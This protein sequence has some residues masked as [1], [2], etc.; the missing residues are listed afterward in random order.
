MGRSRLKSEGV[1]PNKHACQI[2][3]QSM[4]C[5][6]SL[7]SKRCWQTAEA[8]AVHCNSNCNGKD[9]DDDDDDNDKNVT[10][11]I[12]IIKQIVLLKVTI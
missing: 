1:V 4:L 2:S 6:I 7:A 9:D 5:I 8:V 11:T 10:N 12:I 3:S